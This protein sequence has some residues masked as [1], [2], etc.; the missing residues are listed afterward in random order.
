MQPKHQG[1]LK[2]FQMVL[3]CSQSWKQ[4]SKTYRHM[5]MKLVVRLISHWAQT[6]LS[7]VYANIP[8]DTVGNLDSQQKIRL[9][10]EQCQLF[11][12]V[13]DG[14]VLIWN[15]PIQIDCRG[16]ITSA[17]V[18][19]IHIEVYALLRSVSAGASYPTAGAVNDVWAVWLQFGLPSF[20]FVLRNWLYEFPWFPCM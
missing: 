17:L 5:E 10:R 14:M 7:D 6:L 9:S 20:V 15:Q 11:M 12:L 4:A 8:E 1:Y 3:T 18:S 2:T 13:S 19:D 16:L